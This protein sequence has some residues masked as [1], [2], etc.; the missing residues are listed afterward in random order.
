[1]RSF[2]I[3]SFTCGEIEWSGQGSET[4][5]VGYNSNGDYFANHPANGFPDIGRIISCTRYMIPNRG[6]RKRQA[7]GQEIQMPSGECPADPAVQMAKREC[8]SIA[9]SDDASFMDISTL[10]DA[11]GG[12]ITTLSKCPPT[13]AQLGISTEFEPFTVQTGDCHRSKNTFDPSL[14][15]S[16]LQRPYIFISVCCYD[17]NE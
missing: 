9:M 17:A 13:K 5:I 15:G 12:D 3:F 2:Y 10:R 11:N 14:K 16:G 8:V 6:R 1:M 7:I 4:A